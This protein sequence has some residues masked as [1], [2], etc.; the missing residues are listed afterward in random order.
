MLAAALDGAYDLL[1]GSVCAG[2]DRP[3]RA[4]CPA[5]AASLRAA[6]RSARPRPVR[7][8]PCPP[9]LPPAWTAGAYGADLRTAVLAFKERGRRRLAGPL[10]LALVGP[11]RAA[12]DGHHGVVCVPLPA[13]RRGRS[14][15]GYD[16][17]RLLVRAAARHGAPPPSP[18]LHW[19]RRTDDQAGLD[20]RGRWRN[21]HGAL[22]AD[23]RAHGRLVVLADDV[24]T[25]GATLAEATRA[26]AAAGAH[27]VGAATVVATVR[28][29]TC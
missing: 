4:W 9:G 5:C 18:L 28:R 17:V 25:T 15:R 22:A 26:L 7:P 12:G 1:L 13:S 10:G 16:H 3:G 6:V 8:S 19:V 24:L 21:L 2:C 20:V 11:L 14:E 23:A 29:N 27:V